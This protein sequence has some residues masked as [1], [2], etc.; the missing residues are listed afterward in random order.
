MD[1]VETTCGRLAYR[2]AGNGPPLV[3]IHGNPTSGY[4]WRNIQPALAATRTTVALDL[5]GMGASDAV[6][7][8]D[9]C[10]YSFEQ[11]AHALD[12]F[13]DA[14]ELGRDLVLV[15]HDWGA[16]LAF[17]WARK[18]PDD[19]AGLAYMETMVRPRHWAEESADGAALMKRLRTP[20]GESLV[21]ED[22]V[23]IEVVLDAGTVTELAIEH[24]DVYR[25]PYRDAG[26]ARRPMLRWA[27]Q[28]PFDGQPAETATV[29]DACAGFL[30]VSD[31]PKLF[32]RA[33]PGSILVGETAD[34][35]AAFP[36][37]TEVRV[38][39]S[40]FVPEDAPE[41]VATALVDW[42][43]SV[44]HGVGLAPGSWTRGVFD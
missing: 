16:V 21:L 30:Q 43:A 19:V 7:G 9:P 33:D 23:L 8:D 28:V 44:E 13:L 39:A 1:F 17:D 26:E 29:L 2:R 20:A 38:H 27:Q 4:L 15:G 12:E 5:P 31:I 37:Q 18:H 10:R 36:A 24:L 32:I 22:N 34:F 41:A 11:N 6:T 40:H 14:L 42:L 35:A 25:R 3:L